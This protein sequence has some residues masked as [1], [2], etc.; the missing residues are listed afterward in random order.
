MSASARWFVSV[1]VSLLVGVSV[2]AAPDTKEPAARLIV[3]DRDAVVIANG[4]GKTREEAVQAAAE[5]GL[6]EL[7]K[8]LDDKGEPLP[9]RQL[10]AVIRKDATSFVYPTPDGKLCARLT[11]RVPEAEF[12]ARLRKP[13]PAPK[14]LEGGAKIAAEIKAKAERA[15]ELEAWAEFI[16]RGYPYGCMTVEVAEWKELANR[17]NDRSATFEAKIRYAP[18]AKQYAE[19]S[20]WLVRTMEYVAGARLSR[21]P[22]PSTAAPGARATTSRCGSRRGTRPRTPSSCGPA[23]KT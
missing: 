23:A 4:I 20:A 19:F 12:V 2:S 9:L 14:P 5:A 3:V 1:G 21:S 13:D 10:L 17:R 15:K 7:V 6:N 11:A 22:S 16:V 8:R 18:D